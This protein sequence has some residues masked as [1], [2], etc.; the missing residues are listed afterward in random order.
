MDDENFDE[1]LTRGE[2]ELEIVSLKNTI[3]NLN[4]EINQLTNLKNKLLSDITQNISENELIFLC[5]IL[6]NKIK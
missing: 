1:Y 5:K 6:I 3:N 2:L 4:D